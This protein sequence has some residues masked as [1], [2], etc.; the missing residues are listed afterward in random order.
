MRYWIHRCKYQGGFEHFEKENRLTIGFSDCANN[1]Q[2][3]DAIAKNAGKEFDEIYHNIY[4]GSIWRSRWSLWY[5]TCEMKA[6][7]IVVVPRDGGFSVCKLIGEVKVSDLREI[8]DIGFEWKVEKIIDFCGPRE[9]YASTSL[10]SRMKCFQTTADIGDLAESVNTAIKRFNDKKPFSLPSEL[11]DK[12]RELL[13]ANGSPDHF[14]QLL[15]SYF[16][17]QGAK[18]KILPKNGSEKIGDCDV[19]AVFPLL[20][21]TISVQAKKHW[22]QTGDWAVQQITDYA[23]NRKKSDNADTNWSYINWVVSFAEE[24]TESAVLKA[25]ENGI[26]LINGRDFCKMLIAAGLDI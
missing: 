21:L 3:R 20:H 25:Q 8:K 16:A 12:C 5:F 2:M 13:D 19:E 9:A 26:V 23:E 1:E 24:F 17:K 7:D 14:E 15:L 4:G 11:A 10:L 18:A 22:G 6:D